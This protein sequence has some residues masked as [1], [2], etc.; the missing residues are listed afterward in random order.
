M[1]LQNRVDPFGELF[2]AAARGTLMG[3]RGGRIHTGEQKLTR[4]RWAS[5]Q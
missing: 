2:A 1:P 5:K 3:N 4:R